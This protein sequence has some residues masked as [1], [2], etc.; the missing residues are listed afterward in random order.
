MQNVQS[1]KQQGFTL[2]ELIA[3]I[4]I[5]GILAATAVPKFIDMSE[6][7]TDASVKGLA[8][9]LNS[10]SSVN[11][12]AYS[13]CSAKLAGSTPS[14][15]VD[16]TDSCAGAAAQFVSYDT[17]DYT[18]QIRTTTPATTWDGTVGA[19]NNCEVTDAGG[20]YTA[21]FTMYAVNNTGLSCP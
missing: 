21:F 1:M 5:L 17:T 14:A 16:T 7:A 12:A 3:V 20:T 18:I 2:I 15:I 4:V 19:A 9:S 6:A 11:F 10:A 8:G 13:A